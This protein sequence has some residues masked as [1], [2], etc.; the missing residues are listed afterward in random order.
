ML[1]VYFSIMPPVLSGPFSS[2]FRYSSSR[3]F[4]PKCAHCERKFLPD[5]KKR[6]HQIYCSTSCRNLAKKKRDKRH[7]QG[8]AKKEKYRRAKRA[9]NKRYREKKGWLEYMKGY[10]ENHPEEV[11]SQNQKAAKKYYEN[12]KRRIAFRRSEL[13]WQKKLRAEIEALKKA[14]S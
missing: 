8:Y 13:R 12:N 7:K 11:K 14:T 3:N 9:Q 6:N 10:R 2:S 5:K 1:S 4:P